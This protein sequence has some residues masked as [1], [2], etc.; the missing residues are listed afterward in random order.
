MEDS[1]DL[2]VEDKSDH[3]ILHLL[4]GAPKELP[5]MATV[6]LHKFKAEQNSPGGGEQGAA[7]DAAATGE[8]AQAAT[9]DGNTN[10]NGTLDLHS[11]RSVSAPASEQQ[12]GSAAAN[13]NGGT[14]NGTGGQTDDEH[15][16][17]FN[18]DAHMGMPRTD[19]FLM[20]SPM[21]RFG[22]CGTFDKTFRMGSM[23][24][25]GRQSHD[26][27]S[28]HNDLF[29]LMD[30]YCQPSPFAMPGDDLLLHQG[31]EAGGKDKG[32][33]AGALDQ[34]REHMQQLHEQQAQQGCGQ[35]NGLKQEPGT[36]QEANNGAKAGM[37]Y[38]NG[39]QVIGA[40][41]RGWLRCVL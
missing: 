33:Q 34:L 7:S 9:D 23:G 38:M 40:A 1:L 4:F 26:P 24:G 12:A 15:D 39:K 37:P 3:D 14:G 35:G 2:A 22:S 11:A 16:H 20:G 41:C 32:E 8:G 25:K 13:G 5:R 10:G 28:S 29:G 21:L 19:S 18:L 27:H 31:G 30:G 6:H 17:M 36:G